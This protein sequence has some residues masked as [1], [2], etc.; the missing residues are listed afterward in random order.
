MAVRCFVVDDHPAIVD[1]VSRFLAEEERIEM[2][3]TA[4]SGR[5]ALDTIADTRPDVAVVDV[6]MPDLDGIEVARRLPEAGVGTAVGLCTP[7]AHRPLVRKGIDAGG[8][9][10]L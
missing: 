2:A 1:S 8:S 3:G 4:T 5:A 9:R 6:R 7:H 10:F